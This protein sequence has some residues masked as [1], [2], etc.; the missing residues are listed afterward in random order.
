M[1]PSIWRI[2]VTTLGALA[3]LLTAVAVIAMFL[4]PGR[5]ADIWVELAK[6]CI[7]LVVVVGLGGIVG[8][9]LRSV[10]L[11]RD[12]RRAIDDRKRSILEQLVGAYY[13]LKF[14]RRNL[15]T[16][17]LHHPARERLRSEQLAAL[18]EGMTSIVEVGLTIE[19]VYRDVDDAR[20]DFDQ[21]TSVEVQE[22]LRQLLAYVGALVEEWERYGG[23]F[24]EDDEMMTVGD[25]P[26]LQA[27]LGPAEN[28]F[29]PHAAE[30]LGRVELIVRHALFER[31]RPPAL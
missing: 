4:A 27:F 12:E 15:R 2:L 30:H 6:A 21:A 22:H 17:G 19:Q 10:E 18:R 24:W 28:D 8:L 25:L 13:R 23:E 14:V 3:V 20:A 7:Q 31:L 5:Q 1:P 29:H 11:I 26:V 9:V 16:V